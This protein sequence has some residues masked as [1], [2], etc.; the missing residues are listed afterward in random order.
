MCSTCRRRRVW[1]ASRSRSNRPGSRSCAGHDPHH[2]R[3]PAGGAGAR[4]GPALL[5]RAGPQRRRV[6]RAGGPGVPGAARAGGGRGGFQRALGCGREDAGAGVYPVFRPGGGPVPL[7]AAPRG[8]RRGRVTTAVDARLAVRVMVTDVWDQVSLAVAPTTTIADLKRHAL[9][10]AVKRRSVRGED[11]VVK[12]K[13]GQVLD[14]STTLAAL[15]AVANSP[16]IVLPA[17][18]QPVR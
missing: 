4:G 3:G 6:R 9:T 16:F 18:R 14:E 15:G 7:D 12:F 2:H 8:R 13:G 17:R 5:R 10:E 11:Y 1:R